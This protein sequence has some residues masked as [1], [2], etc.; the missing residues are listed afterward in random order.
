MCMA[1]SGACTGCKRKSIGECLSK[2]Q[3]C[4]DSVWLS[5]CQINISQACMRTI[6]E[7]TPE[8]GLTLACMSVNPDHHGKLPKICQ[9]NFQKLMLLMNPAPAN[10][11]PHQR[12]SSRNQGLTA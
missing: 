12:L 7:L 2:R 11:T 3:S 8:G 10:L 4:R 5:R 1:I 9:T 6:H